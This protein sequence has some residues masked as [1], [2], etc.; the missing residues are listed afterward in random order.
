MTA[1]GL[2]LLRRLMG[3]D[4]Q[5]TG[6]VDELLAGLAQ[7]FALHIRDAVGGDQ[8]RVGERQR[9]AAALLDHLKAAGLEAGEDLLVMDQFAV[10][11]HALGPVNVGDQGQG[12][13]HAE[14]HAQD[15]RLYHVH[16]RSFSSSQHETAGTSGG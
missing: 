5:R 16:G 8:H 11:G 2:E 3:A 4:D 10:N 13:A 1:V 12:V 14:A 7:T 9:A 6:G 15:L